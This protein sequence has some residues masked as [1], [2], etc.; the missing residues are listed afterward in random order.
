MGC[1]AFVDYT[2]KRF[3]KLTVTKYAGKNNNG[4]RLW[5]CKCDCGN[6]AYLTSNRVKTERSKSCGCG[7]RKH[8]L[9]NDRLYRIL[10][11]MKQRCYNPKNPRYNFYGAIGIKVCDEWRNNFKSFYDWAINNGYRDDL[12]IDRID[13]NGNYE[14]SNCRW[15]TNQEQQFNK[16]VNHFIEFNG[17]RQTI[18]EWGLELGIDPNTLGTRLSKGWD[19][20]RTL[21]T[22]A[23]KC[24]KKKRYYY[25]GNWMTIP[26]L[27]AKTGIKYNTLKQ[28]IKRGWS[29]ENAVK[30]PIARK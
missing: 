9:S 25:Q 8:G 27:S 7:I 16:H 13:V 2:G 6:T 1:N 18:T 30:P 20:E 5:E 26:E 12:T 24:I 21:T 29:I 22:P 3:G 15:I 14:P 19:I 10:K 17:K 11:N 4:Q 23:K 28:R